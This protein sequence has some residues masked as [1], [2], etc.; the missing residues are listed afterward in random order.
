M[1]YDIVNLGQSGGPV[2]VG[3]WDT[4][5][6]P[7]LDIHTGSIE[8]RNGLDVP[9][10]MCSVPCGAGEEPVLV[11][12]QS[13][14]C[15]TCEPCDGDRS[16]STGERCEECEDGTS[17]NVTSGNRVCANNTVT[18]LRWSSP[19]AVLILLG[20]VLGLSTT[21]FVSVVFVVFNKH[22][23]IKATSRELSAIL[24]TGIALCYILP[25]TFI[26]EPSPAS[27]GIRRFSLGFCFTLC[28]SPLL[29]KT[30]RIYRVFHTAPHTPRF[31]GPRSQVVFT[32][33]LVLVQ[34]FIAVLWLGLE[35]PDVIVQH[36]R[37][38]TEKI[39]AGSPSSTALSS[40]FSPPSML[41]SPGRSQLTSMRPSSL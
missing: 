26:A 23:I 1:F 12:D 37:E 33:I 38:I 10:S 18:F 15:H 22:K 17:P 24:L 39:C 9:L 5:S 2:K 3:S 8:W 20:S 36:D 41:S 25:V 11:Q 4:Q 30:N 35:R 40:W 27:C 28:F 31:A 13:D 14:C 21:A 34:V 7:S 29:M 6:V 16:V 32:C 19:W